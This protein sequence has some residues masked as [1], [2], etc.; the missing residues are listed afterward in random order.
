MMFLH[1]A[2]AWCQTTFT[3]MPSVSTLE[4]TFMKT[5]FAKYFD[6]Q[7]FMRFTGII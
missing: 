5:T 4:L 3:H 7:S 6:D 2:T 1:Q